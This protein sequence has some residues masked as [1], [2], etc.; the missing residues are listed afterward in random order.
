MKRYIGLVADHT[1]VMGKG[2]NVEQIASAQRND[3][4]ILKGGR[5]FASKDKANMFDRATRQPNA[6][7]YMSRPFPAWLIVARPIVTPPKY[8][9]Q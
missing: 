2:W 8:R 1:A 7:P 9:A 3:V 6:T 5:R 4:A